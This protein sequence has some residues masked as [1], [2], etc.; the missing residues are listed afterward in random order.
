VIVSRLRW[1]VL[2]IVLARVSPLSADTIK[3]R[4]GK[5][6]EGMF[7][8]GDSKTVRVLLDSGQVSEIPLDQT[9]GIEFAVRKP[10]QPAPAPAPVAAAPAA[11]KKGYRKK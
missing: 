2:L 9:T 10:P 5:T 8:G 7:I 4:N 11:A 6:V 1:A 3:L